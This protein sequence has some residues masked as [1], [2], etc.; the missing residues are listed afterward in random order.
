MYKDPK[1]P[2]LPTVT[3]TQKVSADQIRLGMF[4]SKLDRSWLETPFLFQGFQ[5]KKES[6]LE[7]LRRIC[8]FVY[9][10][11]L[12]SHYLP[13]KTRSH[14]ITDKLNKKTYKIKHAVEKEIGRAFKGYGGAKS[15]IEDLLER[16]KSGESVSAQKVR[17]YV[18]EC[19]NSIEANPS[20]LMWLT[21]IKHADQYTAEHCLNVG[22][23]A[24]AFGR[25]LGVDKADLEMLGLCGMLHDVG[26]MR[27]SPDILNKPG[28]L[29][30]E[31]FDHIKLHPFYAKEI[32]E[33]DK[34]LPIEVLAAALS[35]HERPDGKGYPHGL[36][37]DAVDFYT[38]VVSIVDAYDAITSRRC[39]SNSETSATALKILY[40][41]AGSQFDEKLVIKFIECIGV[42]PPG[43]LVE[44]SSGEVGVVLAANPG[45]RLQPT[46]AIVRD[47]NK[48]PTQQRI[49]RLQ[50]Q[51]KEDGPP[52]RIRRVLIDGAY[53]I[54][55]ELFTKNNVRIQL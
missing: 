39:Y 43:S 35:H 16:V 41:N 46:V 12:K 29:S 2:K 44:L 1:K 51:S 24:I 22:V 25:H 34:T 19:V 52:I 33:E 27:V 6:D 28:R 8:D 54:E 40:E 13:E 50:D 30:A 32:L 31:E 21:R 23:L 37:A 26:K 42:F 49:V 36:R 15:A 11:V 38:K 45:N 14:P 18:K 5:V 48:N 10:D 53:G 55:L 47:K 20:A 4:I 7:T 9:I 3:Q 17:V